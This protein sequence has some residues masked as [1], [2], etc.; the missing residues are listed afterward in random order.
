LTVSQKVDGQPFQKGIVMSTAPSTKEEL[1]Q[2]FEGRKNQ[3]HVRLLAE[4]GT[5]TEIYSLWED[6]L[7]WS[8]HNEASN[9][10]WITPKGKIWS[11]GFA[12][13]TGMARYM[14][15]RESQLEDAGWVKVSSGTA[16]GK[17]RP[18]AKQARI[19]N[20]GG[21]RISEMLMDASMKATV[22]IPQEIWE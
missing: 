15:L 3:E 4:H 21:Y 5:Y 6:I 20:D 11:C 2:W 19:L 9:N 7:G 10:M 18:T 8:I 12:R 13:H 1:I 17:C 14:G 16:Y 22:R